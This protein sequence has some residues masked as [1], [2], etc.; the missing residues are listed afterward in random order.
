VRDR[1]SQVLRRP[2]H[3]P[4]QGIRNYKDTTSRGEDFIKL[5]ESLGGRVREVLWTVGEYDVVTVVDF[6]DDETGTAALLQVG[7]L[8]NVRTHTMRAF[9]SDEM[10][11]IIRRTG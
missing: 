7:A 6:P 9:N 3:P 11:N 10:A 1:H 8:G 5:A 4:D 2:G